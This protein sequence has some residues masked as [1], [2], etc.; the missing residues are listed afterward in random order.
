MAFSSKDRRVLMIASL[1][2]KDGRKNINK[3]MF[4]FQVC[5]RRSPQAT[6]RAEGIRLD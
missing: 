3:K 5:R 1:R 6:V 4:D 2:W